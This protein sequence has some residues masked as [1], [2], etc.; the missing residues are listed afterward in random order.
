[1]SHLLLTVLAGCHSYHKDST[2]QQKP[3]KDTCMQYMQ[4]S[5]AERKVA[6]VQRRLSDAVRALQLA[7]VPGVSGTGAG[8]PAQAAN[9]TGG[10]AGPAAEP[11]S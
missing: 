3:V 8:T 6:V 9:G 4:A 2:G 10:L 1:M 7:G 5:I 11:A